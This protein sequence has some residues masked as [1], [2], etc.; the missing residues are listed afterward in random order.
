MVLDFPRML[1]LLRQEKGVSQREAATSLSVSQALLSHYEKGSR[2]PGY[3]FLIRAAGYYGVST[4]YLL[5]RTMQRGSSPN[6]AA[7]A[8]AADGEDRDK[9][10]QQMETLRETY[11]LLCALFTRAGASRFTDAAAQYMAVSAY[12]VMRY[13]FLANGKSAQELF[14]AS[15]TTFSELSDMQIKRAEATLREYAEAAAHSRH[16]P[17]DAPVP[18]IS[19]DTLSHEY[20]P[21]ADSVLTLLHA[22]DEQ[23]L[24]AAL[25]STA[26]KSE[27]S[28]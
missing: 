27:K 15:G 3:A 20:A 18:A 28:S 2:E 26:K 21:L 7:K 19:R 12:K 16:E 23:L 22:V 1:S 14:A 9:T 24:E 11:A 5:G 13:A 25:G 6:D 10:G 4:D 8:A 17:S